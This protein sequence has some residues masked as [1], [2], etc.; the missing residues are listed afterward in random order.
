MAIQKQKTL[1]NG[2][3]GNYWKIVEESYNK[4]TLQAVVKIALYASKQY[5]DEGKDLGL[6]KVIK[7][8]LT[9]EELAGDR[10][11]IAYQKIKADAETLVPVNPLENQSSGISPLGETRVKDADLANG[12]DV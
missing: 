5:A 10:T 6:S 7:F 8:S 9:K 2:A 1:S 4:N 11:S 3:V 12:T